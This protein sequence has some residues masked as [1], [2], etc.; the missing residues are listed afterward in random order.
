MIEVCERSTK[1][2]V[3]LSNIHVYILFIVNKLVN[4]IVQSYSSLYVHASFIPPKHVNK[5]EPK[6]WV[7]NCV[8]SVLAGPKMCNQTP[9]HSSTKHRNKQGTINSKFKHWNMLCSP[10]AW[11]STLQPF[12]HLCPLSGKSSKW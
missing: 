3:Q 7:K 12:L 1:H 10:S 5:R 11:L 6:E 2:Q 8:S 9:R 4:M